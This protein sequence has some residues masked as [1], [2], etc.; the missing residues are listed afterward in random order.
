MVTEYCLTRTSILVNHFSLPCFFDQLRKTEQ[1]SEQGLLLLMLKVQPTT[2][3][4]PFATETS[5]PVGDCRR[6]EQ[7]R[8]RERAA[9]L[10]Q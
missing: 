8:E 9:A 2:P 5:Q 3:R 4:Y 1:D 7:V 6:A 10:L